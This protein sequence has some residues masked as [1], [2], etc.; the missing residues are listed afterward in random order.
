[1]QATATKTPGYNHRLQI[2]F[3]TDCNGRRRA[4]FYGTAHRWMPIGV[5]AAEGFIAQDQA[6]EA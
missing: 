5:D 1:M 3:T 6:D 2:R 4:H